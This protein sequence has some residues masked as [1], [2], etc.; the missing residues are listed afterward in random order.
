MQLLPATVYDAPAISRLIQ[1]N[2][3]QRSNVQR[4]TAC[5]PVGLS[6]R[7]P[8]RGR[9]RSV[10]GV[11]HAASGSWLHRIT[12]R[13]VRGGDDGRRPDRRGRVVQCNPSAPLVHASGAATPAPWLPVVGACAAGFGRGRR[14]CALTVNSSA[15]AVPVQ[16]AFGFR[17]AGG[18]AAQHG[19]AFVPMRLAINP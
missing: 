1:R 5:R 19:V 18:R 13:P 10:S 6:A 3:A 9:C 11:R 17:V 12:Q 2:L 4:P 16:E 7:R 14:L 8:V 15:K